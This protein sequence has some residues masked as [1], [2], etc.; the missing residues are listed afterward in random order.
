[1]TLGELHSQLCCDEKNGLCLLTKLD[2]WS[3]FVSWNR[4]TVVYKNHA[5]CLLLFGIAWLSASVQHCLPLI[6]FVHDCLSLS[7]TKLDGLLKK[8]TV[9][10]MH[11][12]ACLFFCGLLIVSLTQMCSAYPSPQEGLKSKCMAII[13]HLINCVLYCESLNPVS[14]S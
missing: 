9:I 7:A 12:G 4:S 13:H 8:T 14:N 6:T 3:D 10:R 2:C 11:H 5:Y 1:M